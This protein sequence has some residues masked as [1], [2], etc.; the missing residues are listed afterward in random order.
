MSIQ[1]VPLE[2]GKFY[3]IYNRGVNSCNLFKDVKNYEH[4]LIL[5]DKYILPIAET[6]AWVLMPNHFH[7]LIRIK[8]NVAY[9]Y[10]NNADRFE[11]VKWETIDLSAC[12]ASDSVMEAQE[13][14]DSV[15]VAARKTNNI[16]IPRA[17][18]HFSHLFSSYCKYYN[19][20]TG[21]HGSLFERPFDRIEVTNKEY[22]KNLVVY[23]HNNLVYPVK[24][25]FQN[26]TGST[27]NL[28]NKRWII[29]GHPI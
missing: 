20:Y 11:E 17:H 14:S 26:L 1:E 13:A 15:K 4:F 29:P 22:F 2:K 10:S 3:H 18:L 28:P 12:E 8:E 21:R 19:S 5:Y 25:F 24:S 27:T 6:Y 7:L 9:K 23:I 16:K